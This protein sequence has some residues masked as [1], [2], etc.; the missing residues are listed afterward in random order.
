MII[1]PRATDPAALPRRPSR[2]N[3][4]FW[5]PRAERLHTAGVMEQPVGHY[6]G[7]TTVIDAPAPT[8]ARVLDALAPAAV[9]LVVRAVGVAVLAIM[10]AR[11]DTSVTTALRAWD[12]S[13]LLTIARSGYAGVPVDMLDAYGH[14]T[15]FTALGFFPGYPAVVAA[16]G[17]LTGGNLVAAGLLVSLVSGVVGAYGLTALGEL[18][19]GGSNRAGLVLVALFAAAPMGVVLSMTYTEALFCALAAWAL[20]GVLRGQWLLAGLCAAGAGLVRP[21]ASSLVA[22]VGLAALAAVINRRDGWRPWI[23]GLLATT[24]LLGYLGWVATRTGELTGWFRIQREGWGWNLDGGGATARYAANVLAGGDQVFDLATLVAIVATIA[25]FVI[26]VHMRLPWPLLVYAT[27]VLVT[28]WGTE[29]LMNSKLRLLLPAFV[30]L[31]PVA[32]GLAKRRPSTAVAVMVA[33]T[34][35]SAW[36]GGYALTIWHYG[37]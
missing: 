30:L 18:V 9:H 22:A 28:V 24:G 5:G 25:L 3:A 11:D 35:A 12:G 33:V 20:V 26:A 29:G 6:R 7:V 1:G 37:I 23:G 15:A 16:V 32:I 27:L 10:A 36:F 13:W 34:F 14:H 19:P 21:T 4:G 8:R 31:V 17:T 2:R